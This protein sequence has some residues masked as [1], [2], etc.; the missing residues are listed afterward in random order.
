GDSRVDIRLRGD[1]GIISENFRD[2]EVLPAWLR[3]SEASARRIG[4]ISRTVRTQRRIITRAAFIMPENHI[5]I[6]RLDQIQV[7]H[8]RSHLRMRHGA[9]SYAQ[10]VGVR[11]KRHYVGTGSG[12]DAARI[13]RGLTDGV[14]LSVDVQV[15]AVRSESVHYPLDRLRRRIMVVYA[16]GLRAAGRAVAG[17]IGAGGVVVV[18]VNVRCVGISTGQG[19]VSASVVNAVTIDINV[20]LSL[21]CVR[22]P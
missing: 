17:R 9:R 21:G 14:V 1:N 12:G 10:R 5:V 20:T 13:S 15:Y 2:A 18:Q 11:R 4:W 16:F 22:K 6:S 7:R 19:D 8:C 3:G